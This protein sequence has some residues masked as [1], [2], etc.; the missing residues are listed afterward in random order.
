MVRAR[1]KR[2]DA[3]ERC[4]PATKVTAFQFAGLMV[5]PDW[6]D[7]AGLA[8]ARFSTFAPDSAVR[9]ASTAE[10]PVFVVSG[11]TPAPVCPP[12]SGPMANITASWWMNCSDPNPQA[13][14]SPPAAA[15]I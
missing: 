1:K 13:I 9:A 4:R 10:L 5:A 6:L 12:G 2:H 7:W 15:H 8:G 11:V 14:P 3:G